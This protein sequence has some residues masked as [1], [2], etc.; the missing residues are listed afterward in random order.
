MLLEVD[1]QGAVYLVNNWSIGGCTI[2]HIDVRQCFLWELKEAG[3]LIVKWIPGS[4]NE[5]DL[6]TK[7]LGGTLFETFTQVYVGED[8]YTPASE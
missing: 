3:I 7:N 8:E 4:E 6:F 2:R 5:S 1:D